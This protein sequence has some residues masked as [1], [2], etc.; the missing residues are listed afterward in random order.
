MILSISSVAGKRCFLMRSRWWFPQAI[1]SQCVT[2]QTRLRMRF[3]LGTRIEWTRDAFRDV[4][5]QKEMYRKAGTV[6]NSEPNKVQLE[7]SNNTP[8]K[9]WG[10][11]LINFCAIG[12]ILS[13]LFKFSQLPGPLAYMASLGYVG[14]TY[15]LIAGLE[16]MIAIV[17]WIRSTRSLGLLLVSSYFGGAISAHLASGHP[18]F[19][20]G[21]YMGY[22]LSHPLAGILPASVF[23]GSAWIGTW[24]LYPEMLTLLSK[25][26][27]SAEA[28]RGH[29]KSAMA[30]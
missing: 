14:G 3:V 10:Q 27:R 6:V 8:R 29:P 19:A 9:T 21:P 1:I 4:Q 24:L 2:H 23:L 16:F 30:S 22:M 17:F 12:L 13:S 18:E 5:K 15:F 7:K 20:R 25:R 26:T 28:N 11:G